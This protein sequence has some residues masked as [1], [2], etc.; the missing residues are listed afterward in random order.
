MKVTITRDDDGKYCVRRKGNPLVST[1][2]TT[3]DKLVAA[4]EYEFRPNEGSGGS[5]KLE[6]FRESFVS[7]ESKMKQAK[8]EQLLDDITYAIESHEQTY[9]L[10]YV[11]DFPP[12]PNVPPVATTDR[13][14]L[15]P[16]LVEDRFERLCAKLR[17]LEQLW[18]GSRFED[19]IEFVVTNIVEREF[20][21]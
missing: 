14:H 21:G 4:L 8:Y 19:C 10:P 11:G 18:K 9:H 5:I 13:T 16:A 20:N 12:S 6:G 7:E 17:H 15:F 3:W 1:Y 2:V